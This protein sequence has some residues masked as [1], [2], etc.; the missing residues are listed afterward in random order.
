MLFVPIFTKS[1]GLIQKILPVK[2]QSIR[3]VQSIKIALFLLSSF[4]ECYP[5]YLCHLGQ[6]YWFGPSLQ[7]MLIDLCLFV[8]VC[9]LTASVLI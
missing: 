1:S 7:L 3:E 2:L 6:F 4:P 9:L 8:Y 5:N